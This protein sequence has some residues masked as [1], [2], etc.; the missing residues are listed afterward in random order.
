MPVNLELLGP[1]FLG[2]ENEGIR[3]GPMGLP[4]I[5]LQFLWWGAMYIDVCIGLGQLVLWEPSHLWC[6]GYG[7]PVPS[8]LDRN[9]WTA[10][11]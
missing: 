7:S 10:T 2:V 4:N 6:I 9:L 3:H 8:S 5:A 1:W 11:A